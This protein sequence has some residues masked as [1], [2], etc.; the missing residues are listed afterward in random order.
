MA[1][2]YK[3]SN[4]YFN[5][6]NI[7]SYTLWATSISNCNFY[8]GKNVETIIIKNGFYALPYVYNN[9]FY[10]TT[11]NCQMQT[12]YFETVKITESNFLQYPF[13]N[14]ECIDEE[15]C[16]I[17]NNNNNNNNN[18]YQ[19]EIKSLTDTYLTTQILEG[20][21]YKVTASNNA[22]TSEI[23]ENQELGKKIKVENGYVYSGMSDSYEFTIN[24]PS[25]DLIRTI[26]IALGVT[27]NLN[28]LNTTYYLKTESERCYLKI[29]LGDYKT[30]FGYEQE[31][32]LIT[33]IKYD[34]TENKFY[35]WSEISDS[36]LMVEFEQNLKSCSIYLLSEKIKQY[37]TI[38]SG[39]KY[40][41]EYY[42]NSLFI[43]REDEWENL[44]EAKKEQ[45]IVQYSTEDL[46]LTLNPTLPSGT[47]Y[48]VYE[49]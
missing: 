10:I 46:D 48:I 41:K 21:I 2:L 38:E 27:N 18:N 37:F 19:G 45:Q 20:N 6:N 36:G 32:F 22:P 9:N 4:F 15:T 35:L 5:Q 11:R 26:Q 17:N 25:E 33:S 13:A 16:Y 3:N 30:N 29:I 34:T 24:N 28:F 42:P 14:I 44:V 7:K 43:W 49:E 12:T 8:I 40:Y 1:S 23:I 47:L 39:F 31:G